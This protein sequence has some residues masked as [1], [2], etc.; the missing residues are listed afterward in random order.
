MGTTMPGLS[1]E[2]LICNRT[3]FICG[4]YDQREVTINFIVYLNNID[5]P[6]CYVQLVST[7][8]YSGYVEET[9]QVSWYENQST[10]LGIA[11]RL[12]QDTIGSMV[13]V[14]KMLIGT[15]IMMEVLVIIELSVN[16]MFVF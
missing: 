14:G 13:L 9:Q 4:K 8:R 3:G 15:L 16:A 1:A 2:P 11:L 7:Y 5:K 6:N 12:Y 10:W